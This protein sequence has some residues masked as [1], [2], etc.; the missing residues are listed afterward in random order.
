MVY[1]PPP[2]TRQQNLRRRPGGGSL[3]TRLRRRG[4]NP[5]KTCQ[6]SISGHHSNMPNSRWPRLAVALVLLATASTARAA[7]E[8]PPA[9]ETFV[10]QPFTNTRGVKSFAYLETGLPALI[11]E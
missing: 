3:L 8:P 1:E 9:R 6:S 10:V 5:A 4:A 7:E 2:R 11:A